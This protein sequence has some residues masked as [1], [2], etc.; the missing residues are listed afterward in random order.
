[1][2]WHVLRMPG[3]LRT[4][5]DEQLLGAHLFGRNLEVPLISYLCI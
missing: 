1:L 4:D 3:D 2:K 5:L